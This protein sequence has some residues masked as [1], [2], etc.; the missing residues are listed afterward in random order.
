MKNIQTSQTDLLFQAISCINSAEEGFDFFKD[1]C[2]VKEIQD[3]AQRFEAAYMLTRG[4]SY[5]EI[6]AGLG[7]SSATIGRVN[8]CLKYGDGGYSSIIAKME[9]KGR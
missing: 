4:K 5:A 3:M 9:D 6:S 7:I 1:L 8:S 2:T